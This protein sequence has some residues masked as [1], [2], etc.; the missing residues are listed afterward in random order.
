M[1]YSLGR[2]TK[3]YVGDAETHGD[4]SSWTILG[5]AY[6]FS[7]AG[8]QTEVIEGE[9]CNDETA[10]PKITGSTTYA[11]LTC[12]MR[13]DPTE[14][15]SVKDLYNV[16]RGWKL[17]ING[18]GELEFT[19]YISGISTEFPNND[20]IVYNVTIDIDGATEFTATS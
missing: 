18:G 5:C 19:G 6:D 12:V 16:K 4:S 8:P 20:F 13:Y 1:S 14:Y 10:R 17:D 15:G 3:L 7:G 11:P 2:G 9:Q